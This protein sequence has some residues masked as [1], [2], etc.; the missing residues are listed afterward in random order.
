M[1]VGE[2]RYNL[3][4]HVRPRPLALL[5]ALGMS[6]AGM[7]M[8]VAPAPSPAPAPTA[9]GAVAETR[10]PVPPTTRRVLII[11]IDGGRP[12]LLL[13]ADAP[14]FRA[15]LD[16]SAYTMWARTTAM[17]ITLPS[18]V[19][20]LTG[21]SPN[22][23][24]IFWNG[25]L[26][27]SQPVYPAVPSLFDLAVKAGYR[28][29]L[30]SGKAK[31]SHLDRPGSIDFK[32]IPP[33]DGVAD[34]DVAANAVRILREHR[35]EVM[36]VHFPGTDNVGHGK[37]W[38]TPEQMAKFAEVDR[39]L[40]TILDTLKELGLDGATTLI[41]SADHGGMGRVHGPDDTRARI[42]PWVVRGPDVRRG[43]DLTRA[44]DL[45]IRTEDT[46]ATAAWLLKLPLAPNLE[47]KPVLPAF[48]GVELM[49]K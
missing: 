40:G 16:E 36:F 27:F 3:R 13:R 48:E 20:M 18:H 19:S 29:A 30:V 6:L 1:T 45:E 39:H 34:S 8:Q 42:I 14:R 15:L 44:R 11:S 22:Q 31:F 24:Q 41:I 23:H 10:R 49:G 5:L 7:G 28:T 21:V 38:G 9:G 37:G 35:P 2:P 33:K 46:F 25:D 43:Y 26:P 17:A 47:G 12:D 32:W 4:M